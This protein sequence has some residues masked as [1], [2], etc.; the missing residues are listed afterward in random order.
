M[1]IISGDFQEQAPVLDKEFLFE[2]R[3]QCFLRNIVVLIDQ[4]PC[5][6]RVFAP[7]FHGGPGKRQEVIV[8]HIPAGLRVIVVEFLHCGAYLLRLVL[9]DPYDERHRRAPFGIDAF[10]ARILS[11]DPAYTV[12]LF[13][14]FVDQFL[15]PPVLFRSHR[16]FQ[17]ADVPD[18]AV[19]AVFH[20]R[21]C[22]FVKV[23]PSEKALA[24]IIFPVIQLYSHKV[25]IRGLISL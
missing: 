3:G 18:G 14:I 19:D 23:E 9:Q 17:R 25:V 10:A 24:C 22:R 21:V 20:I 15:Q 8:P 5:R 4:Q 7:C 1:L 12:D 16:L 2:D 6:I 13:Q 11:R